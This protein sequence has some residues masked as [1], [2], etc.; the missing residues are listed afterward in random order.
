M[1]PGP[2]VVSGSESVCGKW[3]LGLGNPCKQPRAGNVLL[4]LCPAVWGRTSVCRR[5]L[6]ASVELRGAAGR[7]VG[8]GAQE[9]TLSYFHGTGAFLGL[10]GE[11]S[12]QTGQ[13]W[14]WVRA[15]KMG[16]E[17]EQLC[18]V[19][20]AGVGTLTC[21]WRMG[22]R[23][24]CTERLSPAPPSLLWVFTAWFLKMAESSF[25]NILSAKLCPFR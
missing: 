3:P 24:E 9:A 7:L 8:V 10:R 11:M 12:S 18:P 19:C 21:G 1:D 14:L 5:L 6:R 2:V 16:Q 17:T 13:V 4:S 15:S 20:L 23:H 25:L 22:G